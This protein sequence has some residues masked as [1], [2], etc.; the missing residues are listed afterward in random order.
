[1]ALVNQTLKLEITP[2]VVPPKLHV[3]E[4]DEN[5]QVV[6]Q[7]FQRGQYYEIPSGTTAKVDGTLAGHPFSADATVDGSN[8]T[9]ELTKSMTAY[10]GRAWTKIK[11][12][13]DGKPVSTCGFW[14]ECERAGVEAG[15]VIGA[16]G[17]E[18]QIADAAAEWMEQQGFTSP[19]VSVTPITGGNRVTFTDKDG[20][21]TMDVLNGKDGDFVLPEGGEAGQALI[22]DGAGGAKWGAEQSDMP[23]TFEP[24]YVEAEPSFYGKGKSWALKS[25]NESYYHSWNKNYNLIDEIGEKR[26]IVI[27]AVSSYLNYRFM[28]SDP[29]AMTAPAV[30]NAAVVEF[31]GSYNNYT[32]LNNTDVNPPALHNFVLPV[33]EGAT[34]FMADFG[35]TTPTDLFYGEPTGRY[36]V[37]ADGVWEESIKNGSVTEPKLADESVSETK[38]HS[39]AISKEKIQNNAVDAYALDIG[40]SN[41]ISTLP[42]NPNVIKVATGWEATLS[43]LRQSQTYPNGVLWAF[44]CEAGK[45]YRIQPAYNSSS[46]RASLFTKANPDNVANIN[47][48]GRAGFICDQMIAPKAGGFNTQDGYIAGAWY[49]GLPQ[50]LDPV[51]A[52]IF[53]NVSDAYTRAEFRCE[54]DFWMYWL[55]ASDVS[56]D[57][58]YIEGS[59]HAIREIPEPPQAVLESGGWFNAVTANSATYL[60]P[61]AKSFSGIETEK[62]GRETSED[63]VHGISRCIPSKDLSAAF[64]RSSR[65]PA[66][67][68]INAVVIG[69]S[70]T[71]AASNAGLQNAWRKYIS[72][73]LN[74][75]EI[76]LAVSGTGIIKGAPYDFKG[77]AKGSEAY[78]E[79]MSGYPGIVHWANSYLGKES[80]FQFPGTNTYERNLLMQRVSI[81]IVALGTNDWSA[82]S[83]LGSVDTIGDETTFYGAVKKTYTFLHDEVGIPCVLFVAPFKRNGWS[84]PNQATT[85]YTIYDM[86][87][88]LSEIAC[89]NTSMYVL[90]C[91]DRWYLNYDD[92]TIRSRSFIDN[93]HIKPYAHHL[94]T[95]D[96]SK[97]IRAILSAKGIV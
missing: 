51:Y 4:Y 87:H 48:K 68:R 94:F 8:V 20:T 19:T 86:C 85:P 80:T 38:I 60:A 10:A 32:N 29:S 16:P 35:Y 97:E 55:S 3:T 69:D 72:T 44:H 46:T 73:R 62:T 57:V 41:N 88:A 78:S 61:Y 23:E 26:V 65:D 93:V 66:D 6:A 2:G 14:L 24:S 34:W 7:I 27:S 12:T 90:D 58:P 31:G 82:N 81:A 47:V 52:T 71:Y 5:M 92:E 84:Q 17:F 40:F 49:F 42:D 79:D 18:E 22:S 83:T 9:F 67:Y 15:D 70:I 13:K 25:N 96:L 11:L 54:K 33:P 75:G 63:S 53:N 30:L 1:M 28:N 77:N 21:E 39:K 89:I 45:C 74:I 91:L 37:Y 64:A 76:D 59:D 50:G 95:I 56:A 43:S 36:H